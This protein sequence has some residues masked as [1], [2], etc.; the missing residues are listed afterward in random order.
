MTGDRRERD[1]LLVESAEHV[2]T[3]TFNRPGQR[4]AMTWNM[5]QGLVDACDVADGGDTRVM[6]LRGAGGKAF[7][8]G[9]DIAQFESFDGPKGVAYEQRISEVLHRLRAVDVP[10]IAAVDGYCV[11]GGLGIAACADIRVCSPS[12][13]FGVPIARTL[14][15][16]LS[17]DTV[18]LLM[19][20][21][22]R[23]RVV[24]MLLQARFIEAQEAY[25]SGFV[26]AVADDVDA[27]AHDI[28]ARLLSHAPLTMWSVKESVRRLSAGGPVDDTD[29]V[30]R[31]Y[32]S[33]DFARAV[34]AFVTKTDH[35]WE[36]R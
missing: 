2:L 3:V 30:E 21:L 19:Q 18:D 16:C 6:V 12:S 13:R 1:E 8:A 36:G 22:G 25:Q 4:N 17:A 28:A 20:L 23:A 10:V 11:G 27:A 14:G 24:D 31:V 32:G 7:V 15:N 35:T 29:I 26:T 33:Q 5:Y 9:T 34:R